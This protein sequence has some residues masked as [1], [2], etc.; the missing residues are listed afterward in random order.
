MA[1][2]KKKCKQCKTWVVA[3]EGFQTPVAF[4]CSKDCAVKYA[5]DKSKQAREKKL[6]KA[7]QSQAKKEKSIRKAKRKL[8]DND[9]SHQ[10]RLTKSMIQ[11]WVT[12]VR[13][14]DQPCISCGTTNPKIV[15]AGGHYRTAGGNPE[16]ALNSMNI[17]KQCN[18]NCNIH[19]SGNIANYRKG[20]IERYS[21]DYVEFLEGPHKMKRFDCDQLKQIRSYY[22]KLIR[23][24]NPDD[25]DRPF[26]D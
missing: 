6:I 22:S 13:D 5:Q 17:H 10:F 25:S 19:K 1:N 7:R 20:L 15:Y 11:K 26:I 18:Y 9:R 23:D 12:H 16:L 21:L 24:N 8:R 14:K 4:F 3:E 2:K